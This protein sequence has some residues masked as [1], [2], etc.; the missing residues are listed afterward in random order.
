MIIPLLKAQIPHLH[1]MQLFYS[2]AETYSELVIDPI[3]ILIKSVLILLLFVQKKLV[4]DDVDTNEI[5]TQ[6]RQ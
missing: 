1:I 2:F 4:H 6:A 3:S 5:I